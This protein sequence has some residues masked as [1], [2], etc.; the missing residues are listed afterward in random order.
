MIKKAAPVEKHETSFFDYFMGKNILKMSSLLIA[1]LLWQYI[2]NGQA[3]EF[4]SHLK[5]TYILP[6]K[7]V[8]KELPPEAIKIK[9]LGPRRLLKKISENQELV[10]NLNRPGQKNSAGKVVWPV[11]L[12]EVHYPYGIKILNVEPTE[13]EL[14]LDRKASQ[15]FNVTPIF[16][17]DLPENT[18]LDDWRVTPSTITLEGPKDLL[19]AI[20]AVPTKPIDRQNLPPSGELKLQLDLPDSRFQVKE[21]GDLVLNYGLKNISEM[22]LLEQVKIR[23]TTSRPSFSPETRVAMVTLR[24]PQNTSMPE[25]RPLVKIIADI[26]EANSGV[27]TVELKADVPENVQVIQ[28]KP[29][30]V[31]IKIK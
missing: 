26:P 30:N 18:L 11:S 31:R 19:K 1:F 25:L 13:L 21:Q 16:I 10:V 23:F 12:S 17:N 24:V 22:I 14:D 6:D 4:E 8:F 20:T 5:I 29:S 28:I 3:V 7:M 15:R 2:L 27:V 9:L